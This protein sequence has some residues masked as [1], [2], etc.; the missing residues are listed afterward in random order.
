MKMLSEEFN[1]TITFHVL[2]KNT[3]ILDLSQN[4]HLR[5]KNHFY[6]LYKCQ[7]NEPYFPLSGFY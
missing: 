4:G 3:T 5:I 6:N 2:A 7:I 1:R